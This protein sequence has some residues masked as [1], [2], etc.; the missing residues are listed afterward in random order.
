MIS[1]II[2]IISV[3]LFLLLYFLKK[4]KLIVTYF[5]LSPIIVIFLSGETL[6]LIENLPLFIYVII[7]VSLIIP[8]ALIFIFSRKRMANKGQLSCNNCKNNL[9]AL[10]D[11]KL[12]DKR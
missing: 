9:P 3:A 5:N 2:Y 4:D 12:F 7:G 1:V 8:F 6:K 11:G 10:S